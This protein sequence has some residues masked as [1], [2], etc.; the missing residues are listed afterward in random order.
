MNSSRTE[1]SVGNATELSRNLPAYDLAPT[2]LEI[3]TDNTVIE[4]GEAFSYQEKIIGMAWLNLTSLKSFTYVI[5]EEPALG[6]VL[7]QIA[8]CELLEEIDLAYLNPELE[9]HDFGEWEPSP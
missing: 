6:R 9:D 4:W 1:K 7:A 2:H 5:R 3:A 8:A